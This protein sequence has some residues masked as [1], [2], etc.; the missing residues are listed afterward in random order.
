MRNALR[1]WKPQTR[2]LFDWPFQH[3]LDS[4]FT[5]VYP[6]EQASF[7]PACEVEEDENK[8]KISLDIPGIAKDELKVEFEK[9]RL[10]IS[11]ERK[12]AEEKETKGFI[13]NERRYG[14]FA[15]TF[16]LPESV[17]SNKIEATHQDGVLTIHVPKTDEVKPKLIDVKIA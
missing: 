3:E 16:T 13:R 11:G 8:Y 14:K 7:I 15:R 17:D 9:N 1:V 5:P 2:S 12:I 4:L 10:T 6:A